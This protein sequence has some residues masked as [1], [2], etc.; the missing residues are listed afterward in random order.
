MCT[1]HNRG[2]AY[3][4]ITNRIMF[5][6]DNDERRTNVYDIVRV[7]LGKLH[8]EFQEL[9]EANEAYHVSETMNVLDE[10][11]DTEFMELICEI[12]DIIHAAE[13][14]LRKLNISNEMLA[15]YQVLVTL[16]NGLRGYYGEGFNAGQWFGDI[17]QRSERS[18]SLQDRPISEPSVLG[19]VRVD[20]CEES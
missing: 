16:K 14:I 12:C 15:Q 10:F 19:G 13:S 5:S 9:N 8:E 17:D 20:R 1:S 7:G 6:S 3:P 4:E 2:Y 11:G 18:G